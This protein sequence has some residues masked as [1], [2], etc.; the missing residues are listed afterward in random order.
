MKD[1]YPKS[2][3]DIELDNLERNILWKKA[4][5][6][7][8]KYK[9]LN[10][11]NKLEHKSKFKKLFSYSIKICVLVA[12][13]SILTFNIIKSGN[14]QLKRVSSGSMNNDGFQQTISEQNKAQQ[15]QGEKYKIVTN[16][17]IRSLVLT[18]ETMIPFELNHA[19]PSI[20]GKPIISTNRNNN[21][22]QVNVFYPIQGNDFITIH[23]TTNEQGSEKQAYDSLVKLYPNSGVAMSF[24]NHLALLSKPQDKN[25]EPKLF[26]VTSKY[27]YYI[28]GGKSSDDLIKVAD[29]ISFNN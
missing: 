20:V 29:S 25:S 12:L 4:N 2:I 23:T 1:Q 11:L 21:L 8:L 6:E 10:D 22:S 15:K 9:L 28:S 17:G 7:E 13:C 24:V 19:I 14:F 26:I 3:Y 5:N 16:N 18:E 27:I